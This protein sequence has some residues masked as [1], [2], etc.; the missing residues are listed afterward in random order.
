MVP[1]KVLHR[2]LPPTTK[3]THPYSKRQLSLISF[4]IGPSFHPEPRNEPHHNILQTQWY[5]VNRIIYSEHR[6]VVDVSEQ[7]RQMSTL[8][9]SSDSRRVFDAEGS[10]TLRYARCVIL[11]TAALLLPYSS[12]PISQYPIYQC[13]RRHKRGENICLQHREN[14]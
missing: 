8:H 11:G 9:R 14:W 2:F 10:Q 7:L 6:C 13:T 3:Q 4:R 1:I 5:E 12:L